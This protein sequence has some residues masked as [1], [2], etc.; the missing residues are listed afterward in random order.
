MSES[1]L[2][3][4]DEFFGPGDYLSWKRQ[5]LGLTLDDVAAKLRLTKQKLQQIEQN[6]F[7]GIN[8]VFAK[9]YLQTYAK[10]L[11]V[12]VRGVIAKYNYIERIENKEE[13]DYT[14]VVT[15]S[16]KQVE[17]RR[18]WVRWMNAGFAT[19][20]FLMILWWWH[21]SNHVSNRF[22]NFFSIMKQVVIPSRG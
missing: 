22:Q 15:R 17:R 9:G 16:K 10:L 5:K 13:Y 1:E 4:T 11:N 3:L 12:D 18:Y 21:G 19:L 20:L 6:D 7:A 8:P 14:N 2:N